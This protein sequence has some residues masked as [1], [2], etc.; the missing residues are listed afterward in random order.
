MAVDEDSNT[1]DPPAKLEEAPETP[2]APFTGKVP[3]PPPQEDSLSSPIKQQQQQPAS[4]APSPTPAGQPTTVI[5]EGQAVSADWT[6]AGQ[7]KKKHKKKSKDK[8]RDRS[9][10]K[11]VSPSPPPA[12]VSP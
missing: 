2:T 6:E 8:D 12:V 10:K 11:S 3:M 7:L 4:T 1:S 9:A 5:P